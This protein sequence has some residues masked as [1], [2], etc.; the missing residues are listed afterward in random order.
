MVLKFKNP[1]TEDLKKV[2]VYGLDGSGKST[3]AAN[4]C[5]EHG[6]NPVVIDVDDTH[7]TFLYTERRVL[8]IRMNTDIQTFNNTKKVIDEIRDSEFDTIILDGVT[9]QLEMLT[10]TAKGLA[11]YSDRAFRWGRLLQALLDSRKNLIFIGQIDMEVIFT[12]DFQSPKAVIKVNSMVNEKYFCYIDEKGNFCHEVKK[13]RTIETA[14]KSSETLPKTPKKEV[15]KVPDGK[16]T[17]VTAAEV[18]EPKPEDD[19]IR[20]CCIKI[21]NLLEK[22]GIEVTKRSMREEVIRL[23]DD[24]II[25]GENRKPLIQYIYKHCPEELP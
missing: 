7:R 2:M 1:E 22:E 17:F 16:D 12:E 13:F 10:S 19:P 3:F 20:K 15:P 11:K 9:S 21:K 24:E 18:G 14:D 8:D 23:I 25:P 5:R 6:L 4:Y